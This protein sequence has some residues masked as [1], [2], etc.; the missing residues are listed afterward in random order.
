MREVCILVWA[1]DVEVGVV[2][3][4]DEVAEVEAEAVGKGWR[5]GI[6]AHH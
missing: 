1:D 5:H 2:V 6:P 4:G 3:F